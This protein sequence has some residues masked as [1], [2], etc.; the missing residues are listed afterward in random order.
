MSNELI[1]NGQFDKRLY[2]V[3]AF[4][5]GIGLFIGIYGQIKKKQLDTTYIIING[6]TVTSLNSSGNVGP[7]YFFNYSFEIGPDNYTGSTAERSM[8][9]ILPSYFIGKFFPV[10]Y[11][12]KNPSNNKLMVTPKDFEYYHYDYP[13]S[14]K[15]MLDYL[16]R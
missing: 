10:M 1:G 12:A 9:N 11:S 13:D 15:W 5:I 8:T 4:C 2:Y 14:L 7:S 3:L 16:Q 6:A